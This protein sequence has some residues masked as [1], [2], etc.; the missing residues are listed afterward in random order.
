MGVNFGPAYGLKKGAKKG[1]FCGFCIRNF[2]ENFRK[3]FFLRENGQ[4]KVKK[5]VLR[6]YRSKNLFSVFGQ[7]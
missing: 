5:S 4:E 6:V 1:V 7:F 3:F 2:R